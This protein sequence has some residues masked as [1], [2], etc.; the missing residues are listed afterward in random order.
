MEAVR[1]AINQYLEASFSLLELYPAILLLDATNKLFICTDG[2]FLAHT[3][4]T[5]DT[6]KYISG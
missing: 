1:I 4:G 5:S 6:A 2:A 3:E